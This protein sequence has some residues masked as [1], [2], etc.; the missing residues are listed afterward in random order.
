MQEARVY[1]RS[2][3]HKTT[4]QLV[5]QDSTAQCFCTV[6]NLNLIQKTAGDDVIHTTNTTVTTSASA[7]VVTLC[8]LQRNVSKMIF[9]STVMHCYMLMLAFSL[10]RCCA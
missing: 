4:S 1:Q 9:G 8:R 10:K 6:L 3:R 5:L 2:S 7:T